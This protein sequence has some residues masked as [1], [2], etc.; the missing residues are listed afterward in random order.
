MLER[1]QS[2]LPQPGLKAA[3]EQVILKNLQALEA[4]LKETTTLQRKSELSQQISLLKEQLMRLQGP[5]Y[6]VLQRENAELRARLAAF[7]RG[8]SKPAAGQG[9]PAGESP[10]QALDKK[11]RLYALLLHKYAPIVNEKERKTVGEVKALVNKE[12]LT[13][14]SLVSQF[15]SADYRYE[16]AYLKAAK[17]VY[18]H[19]VREIDYV[20]ADVDLN[21]WLTPAEIL[22][23]KVADDEDL[24]VFLCAC[25]YALGD[26]KAEVIIAELENLSTHAF[27]VT[28]YQGLFLLLD[29]SQK[30][31]FEAFVG[32]K[33]KILQ[34]YA[35]EGSSIKRFLYKFNARDYEQFI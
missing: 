1:T 12:D 25:L 2:R 16:Q 31:P 30:S 7:E 3:A 20:K 11:L 4:E 26:E 23:E 33:K 8:G 28:Y 17:D 22:K 29:S 10:Q 15:K 19:L 24:A 14:D 9:M 5:E 18:D 32:D 35:F 27:V 6:S 13:I 34:A 21:F